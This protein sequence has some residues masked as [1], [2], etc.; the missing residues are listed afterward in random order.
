MHVLIILKLAP[1]IQILI[2]KLLFSMYR[3]VV[4]QSFICM[5]WD[6]IVTAQVDPSIHGFSFH[7]FGYLRFTVARKNLE[8]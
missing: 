7:G 8:N 3:E 5:M 1:F 2:K 6:A 4:T